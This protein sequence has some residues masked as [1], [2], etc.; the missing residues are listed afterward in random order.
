MARRYIT[1]L[2]D[3]DL[4]EEVYYV[5]DRQLR[6]NRNAALYLST[7]LRDKTGVINARM[8]NVTETSCDAIQSGGYAKIRGKVQVYQGTLQMILSHI[9]PVPADGLDPAEF[10]PGPAQNSAELLAE[11]TAVIDSIQQPVLK[12]LLTCF[13]T[14]EPLVKLLCEMPAGVKAHHAHRGGLLEH[15]VTLS[16]LANKVCEVYPLLDRDLLLAG[17]MLHDIGKLR[18]LSCDSGFVYTDEGQLLG[19]L[20]IGV[21]MLS[22]KI[23]QTEQLRGEPFPTELQLQLKHLIL[24]HHGSYEFGSPR[25]PMTPVAIALHLIDNLDAKIFEFSQAIASDPNSGS[26][27]T[28]FQPRLDRKIFKGFAA[29]GTSNGETPPAQG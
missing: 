12:Q 13:L 26:H 29:A 10:E 16:R 22:D 7:D 27:W 14:D 6:A 3:G 5:A 4:V 19:H 8:W 18:E 20:V 24:S 1:E 21:E 11:L 25:L 17:V 2:K 9:T 28:L 23:R 15:I